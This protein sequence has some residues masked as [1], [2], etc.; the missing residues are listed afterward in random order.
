MTHPLALAAAFLLLTTVVL[1]ASSKLPEEVLSERNPGKR[2]ELA[3]DTADRL[4]DQ[5]R[6]HYKA[7][8]P[9]KGDE[10]LDLISMLADECLHSTEEAHKSKYWKKSEMR[11]AALNRRVRSLTDELSYDQRDPGNKLAAHLDSIHDKLLAGVM[12]K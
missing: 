6:T 12:R 9:Q 1:P 7:G 2:S 8:Q 4:L 10:E 5:A 3:L 11:I